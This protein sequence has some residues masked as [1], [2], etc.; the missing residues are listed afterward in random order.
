VNTETKVFALLT[1]TA[2]AC[3]CDEAKPQGRAQPVPVA[4]EAAA[5]S[6]SV[7]AAAEDYVATGPIVVE[8]QV[9]VAAQRTGVI[10]AVLADVGKAVRAGERLA[11]L[12]DRQIRAER[13]AARAK[14]QSIEADVHNWEAEVKVLEADKERAEKMWES[15]LITREQLDHVRYKVIADQFEL[16]RER[17]NLQNAQNQARSLDLELEKTN[18]VAP[19]A[20]RVARRYVRVGQQV[21]PGDKLFWVTAISPLRV[22]FTVPERLAG[23]VRQGQALQVETFEENGAPH[24][25]KVIQVSPVVD[26]SSG[27]IEVLAELTGPAGNL[28]PG[29]SARIH[30]E[31]PR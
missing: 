1:L 12:D 18:I 11:V 19:F 2:M 20:G 16:E 17:H 7:P 29:M 3:G 5:K 30:I 23:S 10:T 25:A 14:A 13:D 28:R 31:N 26:P 24:E 4:S 9:D 8:N 27:T 15:Q 22:R 6:P 21:A